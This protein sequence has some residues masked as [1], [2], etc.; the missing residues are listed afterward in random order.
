[1]LEIAEAVPSSR[2]LHQLAAAQDTIK[3]LNFTRGQIIRTFQVQ[4]GK[5][6][7]KAVA[8]VAVV[9]VVVAVAVVLQWLQLPSCSSFGSLIHFQ[10]YFVFD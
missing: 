4:N 1:M 2:A 8:V 5:A 9:A 6:F 3:W 7:G 10:H